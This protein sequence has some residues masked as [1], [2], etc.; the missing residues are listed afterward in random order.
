MRW[1][2]RREELPDRSVAGAPVEQARRVQKRVHRVN[3]L[4]YI[5]HNGDAF[6]GWPASAQDSAAFAIV[7][8]HRV[9]R[10]CI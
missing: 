4:L 1:R 7:R 10:G 6:S 3:E 5:E 9:A 8:L 2:G